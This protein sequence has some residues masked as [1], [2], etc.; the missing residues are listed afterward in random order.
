MYVFSCDRLSSRQ[1]TSSAARLVS[2]LLSALL[3]FAAVAAQAATVQIAASD[4][5]ARESKDGPQTDT[6]TF[7]ITRDGD[8]SAPLTVKYTVGG[9]AV[10]GTDYVALA[11][12]GETEIPAGRASASIVVT[13]VYNSAKSGDKSLVLTLT[14][15]AAYTIDSAAASAQAT[16]IDLESDTRSEVSIS[17]SES[18]ISED[19]GFATVIATRR[20]GDL[21]KILVVRIAVGGSATPGTDFNLTPSFTSITIPGNETSRSLSLI[22]VNNSELGDKTVEFDL[23]QHDSYRLSQTPSRTHA[24]L[25]IL[26]DDEQM[27]SA[28]FGLN[29]IVERGSDIVLRVKLSE[30]APLDIQIPF[31]VSGTAQA[32]VH[33]NAAGGTITLEQSEQEKEVVFESLAGAGDDVDVVFAMG[34]PINA[35]QGLHTRK[36]VT[37]TNK[38][39]APKVRLTVTQPADGD[40]PRT[41]VRTGGGPVH[42]T[43]VVTDVNPGDT[44]TFDWSETNNNLVRTNTAPSNVYIFDPTGMVGGLYKV[45]LRVTDSHA[46]A[47]PMATSMELQLGVTDIN[48]PDLR[49][50]EDKDED[51]IPDDVEGRSD[52][53]EDG[54]VDMFDH[55]ALEPHELPAQFSS[56]DANLYILR[57]EPGLRLRLGD[58]AQASSAQPGIFSAHAVVT[59][60][61]VALFGGGELKPG[62]RPI[63]E[64]EHH[65]GIF[66]FEI[67]DLPVAG[68]AYKVVIP[69]LEPLPARAIYR[70]YSGLDGWRDFDTTGGNAIASAAGGDLGNCPPP[71]DAAYISGLREGHKC[72]QLTIVDGGPNDSDG[73][74]NYVI[75]DPGGPAVRVD[76]PEGEGTTGACGAMVCGSSAGMGSASP[77]LL[78]LLG[79]AAGGAVWRRR[80]AR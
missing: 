65:G 70:K 6:A 36:V 43:A 38:N 18:S 3:L 45:K 5:Q 8:T 51:G 59:P 57:T 53:D 61:D 9:T 32:G 39:V 14:A 63:D 25:V 77:A 26:D 33:H 54:I 60:Q 7:T 66:D 4:F 80:R 75:K 19:K 46:G 42:V 49:N 21:T 24:R 52:Q 62:V 76:D 50:N 74:A 2:A 28:D 12:A 44:H 78:A 17:V 37:L 55:V 20:G 35:R 56:A 16:L 67:H 58:V 64:D 30:P 1:G 72:V 29:E 13:P 11:G 47:A 23:V 71:G 27:P 41:L 15:D 68:K 22:T 69:L 40:T 31:T 34:T 79:I 10:A 48:T 73:L